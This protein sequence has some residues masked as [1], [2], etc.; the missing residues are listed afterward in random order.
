M[1]LVLPCPADSYWLSQGWGENPDIYARWGYSGHNGL[2]FA[3]GVG[4][5]VF[6]VARGR[7]S[8]CGWDEYG[9]GEWVEIQH[10]F[11]RTRYAHGVPESTNVR[12]GQDVDAGTEIMKGGTSGF[13]TGPHLHF[14]C[15][16]ADNPARYGVDYMPTRWGSFCIDPTKFIPLDG[17][18]EEIGD[19]DVDERVTKLEAELRQERARAD[20]N[21]NKMIDGL[22]DLGWTVR[23]LNRSTIADD[24][25][26]RLSELNSKWAG[27]I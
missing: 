17:Y 18:A 19:N 25:E 9:Y 4:T 13:S 1:K 14:E 21:Y 5:P 8:M 27:K 6:A 26:S 24:D 7:I 2:D 11:G 10:E 22:S 20:L 15:R 23:A 3:Y 16:V 12:V